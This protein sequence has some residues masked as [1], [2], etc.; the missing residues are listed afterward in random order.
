[1]LPTYDKATQSGESQRAYRPTENAVPDLRYKA[2]RC[3]EVTLSAK[4]PGTVG[5][6]NFNRAPSSEGSSEL[7]V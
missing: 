7:A 3:I 2:I 1:M 4:K 6:M 5:G